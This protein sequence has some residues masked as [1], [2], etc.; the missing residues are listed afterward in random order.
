MQILVFLFFLFV[1]AVAAFLCLPASNQFLFLLPPPPPPPPHT[2][3]HTA[4]PSLT[5]D[6]RRILTPGRPCQALGAFGSGS[7]L[8][9][10]VSV[11]CDWATVNFEG[12]QP[13]WYISSKIYSRD[14][15]FWSETLAF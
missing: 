9:D 2:H 6:S 3:T 11:Y 4:Q 15:P 8:V 14:T 12:S 5:T 1:V 7:G 13:E 10:P